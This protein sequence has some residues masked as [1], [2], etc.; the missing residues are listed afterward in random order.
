MLEDKDIQKLKEELATKED[1]ENSTT[2][3]LSLVATKEE[4]TELKKGVTGLQEAVQSLITSVDKLVK[5]VD[6]LRTEYVSI[7][8]QMG[9]HEKWIQQLADKLGIKLEY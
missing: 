4:F 3:I 6:D 8:S 7:T 5:V 9:R 2:K 1:L